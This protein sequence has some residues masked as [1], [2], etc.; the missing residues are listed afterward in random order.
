MTTL[1]PAC[2]A[3]SSPQECVRFGYGPGGNEQEISRPRRYMP[4]RE[5]RD[6]CRIRRRVHMDVASEGC[7]VIRPR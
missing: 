5:C 1:V 4:L 7:Y 2:A 6:L 3:V